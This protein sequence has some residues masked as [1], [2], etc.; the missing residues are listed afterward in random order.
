MLV[1]WKDRAKVSKLV[2]LGLAKILLM[3]AW[4]VLVLDWV[5]VVLKVALRDVMLVV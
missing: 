3:V 2:E 1:E 4:L 5:L